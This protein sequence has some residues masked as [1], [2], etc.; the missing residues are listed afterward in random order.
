LIEEPDYRRAFVFGR[1]SHAQEFFMVQEP[2]LQ[3]ETSTPAGRRLW[4]ITLSVAGLFL[5][6]GIVFLIIGHHIGLAH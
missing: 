3:Q 4:R 5:V 6:I 2:S 1:I